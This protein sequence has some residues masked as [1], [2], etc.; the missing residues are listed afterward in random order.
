MKIT[1]GIVPLILG[2]VNLGIWAYGL[3]SIIQDII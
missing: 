1:I 2:M 3:V